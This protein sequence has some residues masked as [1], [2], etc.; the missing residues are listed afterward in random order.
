MILVSWKLLIVILFNRKLVTS[1][2]SLLKIYSH[3]FGFMEKLI[4]TAWF[5]EIFLQF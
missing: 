1:L 5:M 3:N 2:F 4:I